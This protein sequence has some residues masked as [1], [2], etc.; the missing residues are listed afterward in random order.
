MD[1]A[2]TLV[3]NLIGGP[4]CGKSTISTE[5]F[6]RLKKM[7]IKCELVV[8]FIK[9]KIYEECNLIIKDQIMLFAN[10]LFKI[11]TKKNS[12]DKAILFF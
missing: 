8:E 10:Q 3:I 12:K 4:C 9:D 5:L 11:K 1:Y 7:G 2:N 6:S